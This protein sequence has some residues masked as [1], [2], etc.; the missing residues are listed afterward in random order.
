MVFEVTPRTVE[1]PP[2]P[3]S[4]ILPT[5][6]QTP[7]ELDAAA[8]AEAEADAA[9]AADAD[10]G[11]PAVVDESATDAPATISVAMASGSAVVRSWNRPLQNIPIPSP[12]SFAMNH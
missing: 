9:D 3:G 10:A 8:A 12:E 4:H 5:P 2:V 7:L 1:V 6:G 11:A